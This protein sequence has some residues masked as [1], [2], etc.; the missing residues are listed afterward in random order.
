M[1]IVYGEFLG[2]LE[3]YAINS[4]NLDIN[5]QFFFKHQK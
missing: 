2:I 4:C 5:N 3:E 1:I